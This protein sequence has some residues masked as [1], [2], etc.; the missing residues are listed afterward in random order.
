MAQ[1]I[2]GSGTR[3]ATRQRWCWCLSDA[4]TPAR[5][6][7]RR[8]PISRL[9]R[10]GSAYVT[11]KQASPAMASH[12]TRPMGSR[13]LVW[14]NA[15][16]SS[17]TGAS[18]KNS[19]ANTARA[20]MT[21]ASHPGGLAAC[22]ARTEEQPSRKH[23]DGGEPGGA[24]L[25]RA[26]RQQVQRIELDPEIQHRMVDA[27]HRLPGLA[28]GQRRDAE[29]GRTGEEQHQRDERRE[30]GRRQER[31]PRGQRLGHPIGRSARNPANRS[32]AAG[33]DNRSRLGSGG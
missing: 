18:G 5:D 19:A 14:R 16:R 9:C 26:Q 28:G 15:A 21:A 1:P 31:G 23:D 3:A 27:H 30:R 22:G 33:S 10:K 8:R 29:G 7:R 13:G 24:V 12:K 2:R 32:S 11:Q 17:V 4:G 25:E 20:A 6:R